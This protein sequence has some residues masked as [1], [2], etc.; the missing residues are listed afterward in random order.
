MKNIKKILFL[1][2]ILFLIGLALIMVGIFQGGRD[3]IRSIDIDQFDQINLNQNDDEKL[4][5]DFRNVS[6]VEIRTKN[7]EIRIMKSEDDNVH[8]SYNRSDLLKVIEKEN[9][10]K[11]EEQPETYDSSLIQNFKI[12]ELK[13]LI[14]FGHY[15]VESEKFLDLFLPEKNFDKLVLENEI[16]DLTVENVTLVDGNFSIEYGTFSMENSQ[17]SKLNIGHDIGNLSLKKLKVESSIELNGNACEIRLEDLETEKLNI[18]NE[19]GSVVLHGLRLKDT[20]SAKLNTGDIRGSIV[21]EA[22]KFYNILAETER[23][24]VYLN[25]AFREQSTPISK[26]VNVELKTEIGDIEWNVE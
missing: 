21:L 22:K 19:F 24:T 25:P 23:G 26:I 11:I 17:F 13:N 12:N 15:N 5:L 3:L 6:N 1:A 10:V 2:G 16:G 8:L 20:M 18:K 14:L 7:R 9:Q 4:R